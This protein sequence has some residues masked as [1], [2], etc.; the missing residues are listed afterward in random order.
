MGWGD[1]KYAGWVKAPRDIE[2]EIR[3][4]WQ[5]D[6]MPAEVKNDPNY[7]PFTLGLAAQEW[8]DSMTEIVDGG[9]AVYGR[10]RPAAPAQHRSLATPVPTPSLPAS[11]P[12][13]PRNAANVQPAYVSVPETLTSMWPA[14]PR[15]ARVLMPD[16]DDTQKRPTS[17]PRTLPKRV[18][19]P[20]IGDPADVPAKTASMPDISSGERS[21]SDQ[22]SS[23][24][25][26]SQARAAGA[27][28]GAGA[29]PEIGSSED[30][31]IRGSGAPMPEI[32]ERAVI[33]TQPRRPSMPDVGESGDSETRK[34]PLLM[35]DI[36]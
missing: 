20:D 14:P 5:E 35:P 8:V 25:G 1:N 33:E 16:I 11:P 24:D 22:T 12:Q 32:E 36:G 29:M 17:P 13:A 10:P 30:R 9:Q 31:S 18:V 2:L 15:E 3:S 7:L 26:S 4:V 27:H 28:K 23:S 19:M 34:P 21:T 6:E